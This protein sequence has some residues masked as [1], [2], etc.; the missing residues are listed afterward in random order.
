LKYLSLYI[1]LSA[2]QNRPDDLTEDEVRRFVRLDVDPATITWNRVVDVND[3]YLRR[4]TV[5]QGP[6]EKGLTRETGFDITVGSEIMACLA[7]TTSLADMQERLRRIVIGSSRAGHPVTADD[8][9]VAGALAVLMKDAVMPTLMQTLEGTPVLVHA[10]P[11]ANIAHG[12]S[13]IIADRVALGLVGAEGF[14]LTEAGFGSDIGLE[15][16]VN[17]K[18]RASGLVPDCAVVVCT[19]RALKMHGGGPPVSAGAPLPAAYTTEDVPLV[20]AGCA[21]LAVHVRNARNYG[22]PVVVAINRFASDTDAE[23]AAVQAAAV[24]AGASAAVVTSNFAEGGAG[25]VALAEAVASACAERRAAQA[26]AAGTAAAA[27]P[28]NYLYDVNAP[29]KDKIEAIARSYG[30]GSVT[31]TDAVERKIADY[32][33]QGFDKL[34]ICMAKTHLSFTSDPG[35]K[36][37]PQGFVLPISDI[38]ASVGAGFVYPIVGTMSTMPGLPTLPAFYN[39]DIDAEG[40]IT[41]LS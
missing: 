5:G 38:R 2:T 15:K 21:N 18:C 33:R 29:I 19:V 13:S 37:A 1:S 26:S 6:A 41:G 9:G 24:A 31:Y 4:V 17:I 10:G 12:N 3:R 11:F 34:P 36:G 32:Q 20:T 40:K 16:F 8:L 22:F 35:V 23:H 28:L 30:A 7:L 39:I 25:A 27:A 14:V